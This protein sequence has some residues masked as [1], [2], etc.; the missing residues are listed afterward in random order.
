MVGALCAARDQS[1]ISIDALTHYLS[2][3]WRKIV[4]WLSSLSAAAICFLAAWHC[5][6]FVVDE[7][8]Y[9]GELFLGVPSWA[10][11]AIMPFAL[12]LIGLRFVTG[13]AKVPED[14]VQ[15]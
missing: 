3:K 15:A 4:H 14:E 10:A 6:L 2:P 1:H 5:Y 13:L 7:F 11:Q 12:A 8:E 9:G